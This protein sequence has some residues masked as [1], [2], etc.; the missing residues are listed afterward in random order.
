MSEKKGVN[1][2]VIAISVVAVALVAIAA[3]LG[4]KLHNGDS[5][6]V[7]GTVATDAPATSP[8]Y[9]YEPPTESIFSSITTTIAQ[10]IND[11]VTMSK[12][13]EATQPK[14]EKSTKPSTT[15]K[16]QPTVP[17]LDDENMAHGSANSNQQ[18]VA[19]TGNLPNDMSFSGLMRMGYDVIGL[20]EYIYNNDTD[21]D[22]VQKDF[23]YNSLYD[24]GAG[25][26]DFTIDTVKLPFTYQGKAYRIQLWKGQ[27]ISGK[28]G[29]IGGEVGLYTRPKAG[30]YDHYNCASEEDWLNMEMTIFWNEN[31]DGVYLPQFTRNYSMHWWQTGYVDGALRDKNDSSDLRLMSRITFKDT[32][33]AQAFAGA[34]DKAGFTLAGTFNPEIPDTYKIYGKDV[35]YIWQDAR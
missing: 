12:K 20:K 30:T 28:L 35:I 4:V 25:L 7:D 15:K 32:E 13:E 31:N 23:G 26:I 2:P 9:Y 18:V 19:P 17:V 22:C 21:P 16:E 29:T 14:T 11:D 34:L 6:P 1:L 24:W 8:Y 33:Q 27:Y 10:V 3:V 5:I